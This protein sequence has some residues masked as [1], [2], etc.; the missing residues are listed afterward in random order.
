MRQGQFIQTF[1]GISYYPV[2]PRPLEVDIRDIAHALSLLC[3][4]TGHCKFFYSVAEHSLLVADACKIYGP[5]IEFEGLMHDA[6]EAYVNDLSRPLKASLRDYRIA[7]DLNDLMVRTRFDIPLKH[8]PQVKHADNDI[9]HC[10]YA[11]IMLHGLPA[12]TPGVFNPTVCIR[13]LQ[14]WIVEK[15]FLERF[16]SLYKG[17]F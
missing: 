3:R 7:E 9:L 17:V 5:E 14:S 8:T 10:E 12:G 2:D 15:M 6:A 13:G 11:A 4:Y 16:H 1:T